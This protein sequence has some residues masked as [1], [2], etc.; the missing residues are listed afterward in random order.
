MRETLGV[1]PIF[2]P[3]KGDLWK[4]FGGIGEDGEKVEEKVEEE[5]ESERL[6]FG[7][8]MALVGVEVIVVGVMAG[9]RAGVRAE[10]RVEVMAEVGAE[11]R[12]GVWV[13]EE[14]LADLRILVIESPIVAISRR[15]LSPLST[16]GS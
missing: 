1:T 8:Q 7:P 6:G 9:V 12:A 5:E 3:K 14:S 4:R 15:R 13:D 11:V 10:V 2:L 16:V